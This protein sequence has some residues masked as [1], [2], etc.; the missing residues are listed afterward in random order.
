M[1]VLKDD[2]GLL[3]LICDMNISEQSTTLEVDSQ[4]N[5]KCMTDFMENPQMVEEQVDN[6]PLLEADFQSS[7]E[8]IMVDDLG[9]IFESEDHEDSDVNGEKSINSPAT[10]P[11]ESNDTFLLSLV[12]INGQTTKLT[13]SMM[14]PSVEKSEQL[15]PSAVEARHPQYRRRSSASSISID[16]IDSSQSSA[17]LS[18]SSVRYKQPSVPER[19]TSRM[20]RSSSAGDASQS[21]NPNTLS[22]NKRHKFRRR[23]SLPG[24]TTTN[25]TWDSI[26]LSESM[27]KPSPMIEKL[28]KKSHKKKSAYDAASRMIQE[29]NESEAM[30]AAIAAA[31]V[32]E[33]K[34]EHEDETKK[35]QEETKEKSRRISRPVVIID[36]PDDDG[37]YL[38]MGSDDLS[39]HLGSS[40][41]LDFSQS[42]IF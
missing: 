37:D 9:T 26:D 17:S 39:V 8:N 11:N 5:D 38:S 29:L 42:S 24:L 36:E 4:N 20:R 28:R 25:A 41:N 35:R 32:T 6:T 23:S 27:V 1:V 18:L 16:D 12:N 34:V 31:I 15:G 13:P 3:E 14:G 10:S 40:M 19:M 22:L 33:K 2:H 21:K 7:Q 30:A